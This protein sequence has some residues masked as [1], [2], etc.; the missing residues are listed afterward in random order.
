MARLLIENGANIHAINN[1]NLTPLHN[2]AGEG[3]ENVLKLLIDKGANV[4]SVSDP[5]WTPLILAANKGK[6]FISFFYSKQIIN[7]TVNNHFQSQEV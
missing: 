1:I 5:Q 7:N 4:N 3:K 2:A 6:E